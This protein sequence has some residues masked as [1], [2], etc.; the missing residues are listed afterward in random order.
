MKN[1]SSI[2][3]DSVAAHLGGCACGS[4]KSIDEELSLTKKL[5]TGD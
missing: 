3:R 4:L 1:M 2:N 5:C